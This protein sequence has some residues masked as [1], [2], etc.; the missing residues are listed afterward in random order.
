MKEKRNTYIHWP[1]NGMKSQERYVQVYIHFISYFV[2]SNCHGLPIT[3]RRPSPQTN[4]LLF[5]AFCCNA[6]PFRMPKFQP[7]DYFLC[8][9]NAPWVVP[10]WVY[11]YNFYFRTDL[12]SG[13]PQSAS[14]LNGQFNCIFGHNA[15]PQLITPDSVLL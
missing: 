13:P 5:S 14:K 7:K 10:E 12:S 2:Q 1:I 9:R 4:A 3:K 6:K 15:Q 11:L 8:E